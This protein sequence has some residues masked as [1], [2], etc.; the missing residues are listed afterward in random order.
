M[1]VKRITIVLASL[2][3]LTGFVGVGVRDAVRTKDSLDLQKIEL[4]SRQSEIKQLELQYNQLN[5]DLDKAA[6]D[7]GQNE[8]EIQRLQEEKQELEQQKRD[9]ERQLQSKKETETRLAQASKKVLN[10]ATGT[11]TASAGELDVRSIIIQAADKYG[12]DPNYMIRVATCESTLN[13][14]AVNYNYTAGGGH[15]SGLYQYIPSTWTRMSQQ[16]GYA[17]SSV[18]DPV[19]NANVAAWA[20]STGH[21]GE[22]SCA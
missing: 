8:A 5:N 7:K 20:F 14:N 12:L 11:Q 18:F 2:A 9:L 1:S 4:Q 15:P 13:P 21:A 19:A 10:A 16:A 6:K 17:G 3:L 22:W